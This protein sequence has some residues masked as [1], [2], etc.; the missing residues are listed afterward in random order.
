MTILVREE[1]FL[2]LADAIV[3][4]AKD[5]DLFKNT[6][7]ELCNIKN[8]YGLVVNTQKT[9]YMSDS[10]MFKENSELEEERV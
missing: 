1:N 10:S 5:P 7:N 3:F 4:L 8:D 6:M 2:I 9:V